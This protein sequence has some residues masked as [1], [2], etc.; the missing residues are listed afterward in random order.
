MTNFTNKYTIFTIFAFSE[1]NFLGILPIYDI[2][3]NTNI[4][5][6]LKSWFSE[7]PHDFYLL[8]VLCLL[9]EAINCPDFAVPNV[10]LSKNYKTRKKKKYIIN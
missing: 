9:H 3:T 6:G 10:Y 4:S 7:N 1:E 5:L 8:V 2:D